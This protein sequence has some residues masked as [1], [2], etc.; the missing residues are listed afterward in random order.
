MPYSFFCWL[1]LA[2]VI[3][4]IKQKLPES[5]RI[6]QASNDLMISLCMS[7]LMNVAEHA[8]EFCSAQ[9]KKTINPEHI[10]DALTVS[11]LARSSFPPYFLLPRNISISFQ[12]RNSYHFGSCLLEHPNSLLSCE[13]L[14]RV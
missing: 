1:L 11:G 13:L 6:H 9:G 8:N 14:T 2:P 7:F 3:T 12:P 10:L 5:A 4:L